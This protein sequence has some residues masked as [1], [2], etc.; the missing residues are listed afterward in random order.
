MKT[1]VNKYSTNNME[2]Q[3]YSR[4]IDG[5]TVEW[6]ELTQWWVIPSMSGITLNGKIYLRDAHKEQTDKKLRHEYTH[7]LQQ[8]E[9]GYFIFLLFYCAMWFW[10]AVTFQDA[11]ESIKF[12]KEAYANQKKVGYLKTRPKNAWRNY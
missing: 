1:K 5:V 9:L 11:Y 7:V 4:V 2:K 8:L 12:A 6:Q 10:G 3:I